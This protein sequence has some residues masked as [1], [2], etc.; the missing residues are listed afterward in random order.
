MGGAVDITVFFCLSK[1]NKLSVWGMQANAGMINTAVGCR[2]TCCE[3]V[4]VGLRKARGKK[5]G[6]SGYFKGSKQNIIRKKG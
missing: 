4:V 6:K 2:D 1:Q 5:K 3:G